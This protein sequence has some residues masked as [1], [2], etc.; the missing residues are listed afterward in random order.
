MQPWHTPG[1][2]EG[3]ELPGRGVEARKGAFPESLGQ[4]VTCGREVGNP[5]LMR[6]LGPARRWRL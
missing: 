6:N 5:G 1:K 3:E 2:G 4:H